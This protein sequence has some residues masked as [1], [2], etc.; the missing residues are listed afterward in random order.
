MGS[1][2]DPYLLLFVLIL[3]CVGGAKTMAQHIKW[4]DKG[5]GK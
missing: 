5:P 4:D 1:L 2:I 3:L